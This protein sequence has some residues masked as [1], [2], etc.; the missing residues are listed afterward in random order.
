MACEAKS[1]KIALPSDTHQP[2]DSGA[3]C[4]AMA[5][6]DIIPRRYEEDH[7]S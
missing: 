4:G 6:M 1:A 5:Q 3:L 7:V 2:G